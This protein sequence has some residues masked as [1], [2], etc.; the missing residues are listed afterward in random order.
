MDRS[1]SPGLAIITGRHVPSDTVTLC[2]SVDVVGVSSIQNN[3][4][5]SPCYT[6]VRDALARPVP[7]RKLNI[8]VSWT[9]N[10]HR[11][12]HSCLQHT[13]LSC[14]SPGLCRRW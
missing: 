5:V 14:P 3:L 13:Q 7:L 11:Q 10:E 6:G 1:H 12:F 2:H 9:Y 4:G 8:C